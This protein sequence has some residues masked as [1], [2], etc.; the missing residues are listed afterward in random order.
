MLPQHENNFRLVLVENDDN[1]VFFMERALQRAGLHVPVT[2]LADGQAAIDYFSGLEKSALPDLILLDVKIPGRDGFE[3]LEWLRQHPDFRERRVIM[4]TS[5]DDPGDI[6][7]A[8][9]LGA[10]QFLTKQSDYRDVVQLL[11]RLPQPSDD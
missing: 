8:R 11:S 7:R 6:R 3:V 4:L 1:D 10:D 5:S 9:A 2:W